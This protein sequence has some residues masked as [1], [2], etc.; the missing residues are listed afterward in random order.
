[1]SQPLPADARL[2]EQVRYELAELAR[3]KDEIRLKIHLAG[4]DARSTWGKLEK[5]LEEL[6][7]RFAEES[8]HVASATRQVACQLRAAFDDLG[9][10]VL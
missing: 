6:E 10:H 8:D 7:R 5:Q 1:M 4:M 9:K 2:Y 3:M